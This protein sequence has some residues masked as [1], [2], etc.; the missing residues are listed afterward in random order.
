MDKKKRQLKKEFDQI[1]KL[2]F[3]KE[4]KEKKSITLMVHL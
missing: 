4:L 3:Y 2:K 1:L